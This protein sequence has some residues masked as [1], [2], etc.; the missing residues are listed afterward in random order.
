MPVVQFSGEG[1]WRGKWGVKRG[2]CDTVSGRGGD[3]GAVRA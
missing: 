2:E 1:K 3:A